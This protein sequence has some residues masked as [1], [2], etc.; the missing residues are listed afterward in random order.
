MARSA[1]CKLF[2]SL[3]G[4]DRPEMSPTDF[5]EWTEHAQTR[6]NFLTEVLSVVDNLNMQGV[7]FQWNFPGC[8]KVK[9]FK[10]LIKLGWCYIYIIL[11]YI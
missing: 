5:A 9:E 3:G 1:G 6:A 10:A 7:L 8:P 4:T 11:D 2:L